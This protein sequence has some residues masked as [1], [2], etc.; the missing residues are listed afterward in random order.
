M[1]SIETK[2][3]ERNG[4]TF[5]IRIYADAYAPNP[6]EAW[7]EMGTILSL[8]SRHNNYDPAGIEEAIETNRDAVKLSY[9]EHGLCRWSVA[10][11]L[12]AADHC[13]WDSVS[14]AGIWLPDAET[15][16]SAKPYGGRTRQ[17]FMRKRAREACEVYTQW[18]NGDVYGYE[19]ERD[20]TCK[21]C[22]STKAEPLDSCWGLF[23]LDACRSE[24]ESAAQAWMP[25]AA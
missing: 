15:L 6:L 18:C 20:H 3:L 22:G 4:Q 21:E 24:A 17:L 19:I 23:G 13:P 12:P 9:Y 2:T 5:R 8:N 10:G 1:E 16:E 7:S 11:E 25:A 14:F